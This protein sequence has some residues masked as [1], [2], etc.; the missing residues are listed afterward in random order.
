MVGSLILLAGFEMIWL[1]NA[2]DREL[3]ILEEQQTQRL[4]GIVRDLE[5]SLFQIA[6]AAPQL[7][8]L[9]SAVRVMPHFRFSKSG[10]GDDS[11]RVVAVMRSLAHEQHDTVRFRQRRTRK[12]AMVLG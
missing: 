2:Y 8:E 6:L 5:D 10:T 7:A 9:D 11:T 12:G 4:H 3:E 1:Q